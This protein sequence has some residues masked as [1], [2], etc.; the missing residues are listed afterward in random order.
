MSLKAKGHI[1]RRN[2]GSI[3]QEILSIYESPYTGTRLAKR[4]WE[5]HPV[6]FGKIAVGGVP[7]HCPALSTN[8]QNGGLAVD[9]G[10]GTG[11]RSQK[12]RK[13]AL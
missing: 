13:G 8:N 3:P 7:A 6:V 5:T 2:F 9:T 11:E 10:K 4:A 12:W 1:K